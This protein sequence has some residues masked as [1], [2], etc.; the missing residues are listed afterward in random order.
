VRHDLRGNLNVAIQL[1]H[2]LEHAHGRGL[3]HRDLKSENILI[4]EDGT[5]KVTDFGIAKRGAVSTAA[6]AVMVANQTTAWGTPGYAAPEQ[7]IPGAPIDARADLFALGVCLYELFCFNRPYETTLGPRQEPRNPSALRRD[8]SH[9]SLP[10]GLEPL[11]LRL[12]AWH[13]ENR[14]STAQAVRAELA[15]IYRALYGEESRYAKLPELKLTASGHNNRGVS[16]HFLGKHAEAEAA[17]KQALEADPL[18]PE[19]TYNLGLMNWRAQT[20][21]SD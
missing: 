11:L 16:Y 4:T 14:P 9:L 3:I 21:D 6:G 2:A 19:A 5:P 10:H 12:V 18:H 17:F 13:P 15:A 8:V 7:T 20:T 1:C